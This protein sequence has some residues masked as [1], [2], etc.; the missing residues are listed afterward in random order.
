MNKK[1]ETLVKGFKKY[2]AEMGYYDKATSLLYWDLRTGAPKKGV[3]ERTKV[4]TM[5]SGKSFDMSTSDEMGNYLRDL[6]GAE[7]LD[8]I[9]KAMVKECSKEYDRNKKIPK[10]RFQ[11]YVELRSESESIWEEAKSKSDFEMFRPYLEKMVEFQKEF[12]EYWGYK[13]SKY[14]TLLDHYEPDMTVKKVDGLFNDLRKG[15]VPLVKNIQDSGYN[16]KSFFDNKFDIE[17][18]KKF[19]NYILKEI[20]YDFEAGR[21]DESVHPFTI[22]ITPGDVR[23][24]TRYKEDNFEGALFGTIHEGGHALYEQN[25]SKNLNGTSLCSGTSSA[26]HESQSRFWE[27][28]IGRS[29]GFWKKYYNELSS[30]FPNQAKKF[31]LEDFYKGMNRVQ[32]SLIRVDADECTYNLHIMIRYEIEKGLINGEIKVKDLPEIWNSKMKEYLGV[33]PKNDGEGVL[34]DVHWS[35]GMFGYFPT[36]ALGNLYSAQI[37][38]AITK[39]IPEFYHLVEKGD[40][41]LIIEFLK[42][43][44]Y[45]HGKLLTPRDIIKNISGE[46]LNGKYL[47]DYLEKKYKSIYNV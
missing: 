10:D 27:N 5:L 18:Q 23:V 8:N 36:Y 24:T 25:I 13:D 41:N 4:I 2:V 45:K 42:G 22:G 12:V 35:G 26:I 39:E 29:M 34:Q 17:K 38:N 6:K 31:T 21:L 15:L 43:R 28:I 16:L 33:T 30:I 3:T 37:L 9:T 47:V 11:E 46:E 7:E 14:D 40:F 44:I 19:C 20:G 32:P 1:T